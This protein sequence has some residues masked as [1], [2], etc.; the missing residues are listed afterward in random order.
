MRP[1]IGDDPAGSQYSVEAGPFARP[2]SFKNLAP[3]IIQNPLSYKP[4]SP[5]G[6]GGRG[7]AYSGT[8]L[9]FINRS[10]APLTAGRSTNSSTAGSGFNWYCSNGPGP[11]L[12]DPRPPWA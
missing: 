7:R 9:A 4:P 11:Q 6:R 10:S 3:D 1:Y 2:L 12:A 8:L 5:T